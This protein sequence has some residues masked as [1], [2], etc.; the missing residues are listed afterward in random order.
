MDRILFENII[1]DT[2]AHLKD[3]QL[4]TVETI[5]NK[6]YNEGESKH[7]VAD[8]VGLG[9]TIVAKGL[10]AKILDDHLNSKEGKPLR[11]VYILSLIHI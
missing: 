8:E 5:Y 3:F 4:K 10:I 7:L 1:K 9:K 6:L 2:L 11:V